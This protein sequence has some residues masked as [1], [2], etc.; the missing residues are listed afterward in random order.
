MTI[1]E[2]IRKQQQHDCWLY[3]DFNLGEANGCQ[4]KSYLTHPLDFAGRNIHTA[5]Q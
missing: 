4:K 2:E 1:A 5:L 3:D